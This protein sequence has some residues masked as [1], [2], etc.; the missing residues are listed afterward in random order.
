MIT[1]M[2]LRVFWRNLVVW[3]LVLVILAEWTAHPGWVDFGSVVFGGLSL[4]QVYSSGPWAGRFTLLDCLL[5]RSW[6][7][8]LELSVL[9]NLTMVW[10]V[11]EKSE[12]NT[13]FIIK[14]YF[15]KFEISVY[16]TAYQFRTFPN[17]LSKCHLQ[18]VMYH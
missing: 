4:V 5:A 1:C 17:R 15:L 11:N 14:F 8:V 18:F 10:V 2:K 7:W 16:M 12:I 13:N 6:L 3:D 9:H